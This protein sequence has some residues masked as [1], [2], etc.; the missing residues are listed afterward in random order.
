MPLAVACAVAT[1]TSVAWRNRAPVM[2]V[3]VA[4][5][6]LAGYGW[7]TRS[8]NLLPGGVLA[9]PLAMYTAGTRGVSRR[10]RLELA[11]LIAY[12]STCILMEA[13][14]GS[15]PGPVAAG[16]VAPVAFAAGVGFLVARQRSLGSQLAAAI[17]DLRAAQKMRLAVATAHERNRVARD[18]HDVVTHGV[19]VMVIQARAARITAGTEPDLAVAALREVTTAG[20]SAIDELRR[21]TGA[22][23]SGNEGAHR[24]PS[25]LAAVVDLVECRRAAGLSVQIMA[26]GHQ[27]D[28]PPAADAA[29]YRLVQ[30]SLTNVVKHAPGAAVT[31][32]VTCE[33]DE[34]LISI[35]NSAPA[36]PPV[37][38]DGT[39][40]GHGLTGMRERVESCGGQLW[41]GSRP[42]G[43]FEVR[44]RVPLARP[45][46][47]GRHP[48]SRVTAQLAHGLRRLGAWPGVIVTLGALCAE[49]FL[50][51]DRRGSLVLNVGLCAA[52]ALALLWRRRSPLTFLIVI[53]LLAFPIS[54]GLTSISNFTLADTFV[55]VVPIWTVAAWSEL[56]AAV[57]GLLVTVGFQTA[58]GLY[59]HLGGA[60][61]AA[62]ALP[63]AFLWVAARVMYSQRHLAD[64]LALTLAKV[65]AAQQEREQFAL[66]VARGQMVADLHSTV[67]EQVQTM[68]GLAQSAWQVID[69]DPAGAVASISRI[70]RSGRD[71]LARLREILGLL[72]ADY[73]PEPRSFLLG[74]EQFRDLVTQHHGT[75]SPARLSVSGAPAP[76]RGGVDVMAYRIIEGMLGSARCPAVSLHFGDRSLGLNFMLAD[77]PSSWPDPT[78]RTEIER[79][80]GSI[81]RAAAGS[82]EQVTVQLPLASVAVS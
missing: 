12:G 44:A 7:L 30:E 59:W 77:G 76:L 63:T 71:A 51:A 46:T 13:P 69:S 19:S 6:G 36:G 43:G 82:D 1:A 45:D 81:R 31:V 22:M 33:A 74:V 67:A 18:L 41:H 4:G 17:S 3:A 40:R 61:I 54:N 73:D 8:H 58:E 34:I 20:R 68:S 15:V 38:A 72:R 24:Q 47:E 25:G 66:A 39:G 78:T 11:G 32:D 5:A 10:Q 56:P 21:I 23:T 70:E 9:L 75:G 57:A 14:M 2:A 42:D 80:G 52:M 16:W 79:L 27:R 50:S 64:D 60:A 55:F 35:A 49:A 28:L 48:V 65:E 37:P 53:N 62:S 26:V 29:L